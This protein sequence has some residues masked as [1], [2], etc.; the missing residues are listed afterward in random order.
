MLIVIKDMW[1][2]GMDVFLFDNIVKSADL[3]NNLTFLK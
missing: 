1:I 3:R 2:D